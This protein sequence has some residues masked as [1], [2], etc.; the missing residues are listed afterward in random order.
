MTET[1]V[2]YEVI[3]EELLK[4]PETRKAYDALETAYQVACLRIERGLTQK[5]LA[6]LVGT[7]QPSIAR[8]ESG[9]VAPSLPFLNRV[10]EALG[11]QLIVR[12]EPQRVHR[13]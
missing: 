6:D 11:G 9:K 3:K 10:V 8:L 7:K 13:P 4:D 12:I 5:Q 2:P 1:T